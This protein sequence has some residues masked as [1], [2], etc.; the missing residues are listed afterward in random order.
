[1]IAIPHFKYRFKRNPSN[2]WCIE[3][4]G[5]V[6]HETS[7]FTELNKFYETFGYTAEV[8]KRGILADE[9]IWTEY[10]A[11]EGKYAD[12]Y[13]MHIVE[14]LCKHSTKFKNLY[15]INID[16]WLAAHAETKASA[17]DLCVACKTKQYCTIRTA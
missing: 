16:K 2:I 15:G 1:M 17:E 10:I 8:A 14:Y 3:A 4:D 5:Q 11:E 9:F 7:D 12:C 6:V 13:K